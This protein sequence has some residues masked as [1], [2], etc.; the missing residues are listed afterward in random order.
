LKTLRD[1]AFA[2]LA[3]DVAFTRR[4]GGSLAV[5]RTNASATVFRLVYCRAGLATTVAGDQNWASAS[6]A[7]VLTRHVTRRPAIPVADHAIARNGAVELGAFGA[8]VIRDELVAALG[9]DVAPFVRIANA[10]AVLQVAELAVF[11]RGAG[12]SSILRLNNDRPG[13]VL[14]RVRVPRCKARCG[15]CSPVVPSRHFAVD[16]GAVVAGDAS[17]AL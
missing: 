1:V 6:L 3:A 9:A 10:G 13:A 15:T 4:T 16:L 8:L 17:I 14:V 7:P 12:R 2:A 5:I 11:Q